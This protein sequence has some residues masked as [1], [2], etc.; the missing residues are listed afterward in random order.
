MAQDL[1]TLMS[2]LEKDGPAPI[3]QGDEQLLVD[4]AVRTILPRP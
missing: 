4:G 2:R 3:Y 1:N